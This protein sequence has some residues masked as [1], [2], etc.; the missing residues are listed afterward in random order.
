MESATSSQIG[1]NHYLTK[2]M[3]PFEF[4]GRNGWDGFAHTILKYITRW[5]EKGGLQ[6]LKKAKH[7]AQLRVDLD[8]EYRPNPLALENGMKVTIMM[9]TYVRLN[10]IPAEDDPVFY[11]L[12]HWVMAGRRA[13]TAR[14]MFFKHMDLFIERASAEFG[15]N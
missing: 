4:S 7:V 12:E 6:D 3:Q 8:C 2:A 10:N 13:A 11:A 15:V 14:A 1:G 9:G 5:R